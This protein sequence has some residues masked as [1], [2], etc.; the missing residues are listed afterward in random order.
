VRPLTLFSVDLGPEAVAGSRITA[1]ISPDGRRL[2]FVARGQ[3]G[4]EQLATR[5]L[6]Q[7]NATPLPE[8]EN[9]TD[10]FFSP[11]GLWVGFY[12]DG[13]LKK[14][15]IQGGA[16]VTLCDAPALR[17]ASWGEDGSIIAT[18][19]SS[20]GTGLV[21]V[22]DSGGVPQPLTNPADR[23]EASNR[24]PQ[25]LPGG[26]AVLFTG[27]GT[28]G[29]YE[30]SNIE[31][32]SLKTGQ[33]KTVLKGGYFGRY[34]PISDRAGELVYVHQGT[35]FGVP[36]NTD[37]METRGRP[38][39]LLED[40]AGDPATA[41]GQFDFSRDGTFVYLSGKSSSP[42]W[43]LVW[44]DSSGKKEPLLALNGT[45]YT[46]RLSPDGK[47]L[48]F[49]DR[50]TNIMTYDLR[51]E[52]LTKLTFANS[53][54]EP[55]W[56][57]DGEHLVFLS[58]SASGFVLQWVRSDGAGEP[59][60]LLESKFELRP[61]SFSPD[62]NRLAFA[63]SNAGGR[64]DIWTLPL[65]LSDREHPKAGKPELFLSTMFDGY[66]PAF[67]PDGRWIAYRSTS[68]GSSELFVQP[69]PGPGGKWFIGAGRHPVWSK[70]GKELFYY[71][72][73]DRRI[74]VASYSVK[75]D[76]FA[77][78]KP[79]VWSPTQILEPNGIFWNMDLAPDGKRIVAA[80]RPD[81][82]AL[83]KGSVHVTVML[84]FFD[85]LRRRTLAG[86]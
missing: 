35:L 17:G 46:F 6:D 82:A 83:Q 79:R 53:N 32:L 30:E 69:F 21:R 50:L 12:A 56:T 25:I 22:P 26:G 14:A 75:G 76:S 3:G 19:S 10:P 84:N 38:V 60:K 59:Q 58:A 61:Y 66:E 31:V 78:D 39:P 13:K 64:L 86:Q 16:A 1:A 43:Q 54:Y 85:E 77:P 36:F 67:S 70:H 29:S 72:D 68:G 62:G 11:D 20:T 42:S 45:S 55:V 23:S 74:M 34:L 71:S 65:D 2:V 48:A 52:T 41:G 81:T 7:S 49:S 47:R 4:K 18:L 33:V 27:S 8:T 15:S 24:M 73:P 40:V 80:P 57:P 63:Q 51:R 44:L 9:A 5:L 37:R 28:A